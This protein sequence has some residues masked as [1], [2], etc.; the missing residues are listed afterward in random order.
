MVSFL[1]A[2]GAPLSRDCFNAAVH[3]GQWELVFLL[4]EHARSGNHSGVDLASWH[5]VETYR[6]DSDFDARPVSLSLLH[7]AAWQGAAAAVR[8]LLE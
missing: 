3:H 8:R 2:R 7:A 6:I 5:W 1:L 4:L